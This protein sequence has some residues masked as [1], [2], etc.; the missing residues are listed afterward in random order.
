[1]D[2]CSNMALISA[3]FARTHGIQYTSS[4]TEFN[5][6]AGSTA[7]VLGEVDAPLFLVLNPGHPT[8]ASTRSAGAT[9]FHVMDGVDHMYEVLLPVQIMHELGAM[10]D[11]LRERLLYRPWLNMDGA[12]EESSMD[13]E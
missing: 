5:N 12:T 1:M 2:T 10:A 6:S 9:T 4:P 3:T 13:V 11:P 7:R 8:Q